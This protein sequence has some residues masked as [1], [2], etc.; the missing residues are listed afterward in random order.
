MAGVLNVTK[1]HAA[2]ALLLSSLLLTAFPVTNFGRAAQACDAAAFA[3]AAAAARGAGARDGRTVLLEDGREVRLAGLVIPGAAPKRDRDAGTRALADRVTGQELHLIETGTPGASRDRYGRLHAWVWLKNDRHSLQ[4]TLIADGQAMLAGAAAGATPPASCAS[5]LHEAEQS[6]R[7]TGTGL[8]ANPAAIKNAESPGQIV[9][10]VG[11][12]TVVEGQ[13]RSIREAGGTLYVNFG[14]RW[15]TGF[16]VPLSGK[17]VKVLEAAGLQPRAW[18]KRRIR[19][20]GWVEFRGGP[21]M[22]VNHPGQVE[23]LTDR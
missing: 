3:T 7:N 10:L 15:I 11:Q 16:A 1:S 12:F 18:E 8:W 14:R 17:D 2:T 5:A 19:V 21:R 9:P 20:R 4:Q 23:V 13:V 22:A 6:A